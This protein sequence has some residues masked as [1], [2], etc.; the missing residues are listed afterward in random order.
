MTPWDRSPEVCVC[1][2][3]HYAMTNIEPSCRG[4]E[5]YHPSKDR[6]GKP[7]H[8][9]NA[10]KTLELDEKHTELEPW[11]NKRTRRAAKR[12]GVRP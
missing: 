9:V 11:A 6:E 1:R 12:V 7:I 3:C 8:C 4:G 2:R 10:G 5:F